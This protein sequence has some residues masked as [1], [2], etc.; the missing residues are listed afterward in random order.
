MS[1]RWVPPVHSPVFPGALPAAIA[2]AW[3]WRVPDRDGIVEALKARYDASDALLTDSGTSALILALQTIGRGATVAYPAY[4]CFDLTTAALGA[5][6]CVRLYDLD[7]QSLSPDLDSVREVIR[8]GVD[9]IVVAHLYGYAADVVGVKKLAADH[10][11]PVIEDA[12]QGAGGSLNGRR[13]GSLADISI[14]SFG[15]GK[16]MTTGSGGAVLVRTQALAPSIA[17]MRATI[18]SPARGAREAVSLGAQWLFAHP[19]LYRIPASIP[20]LRLGEM[21]FHAPKVPR[22][23]SASA[24]SLLPTALNADEQ[25][26]RDRRARVEDLVERAMAARGLA[27]VRPIPQSEP[28]YLRLPLLD[29]VGN[30]NPQPTI[31]AVRGYPLTLEQHTQLQALLA[32]KEHAGTGAIYLRD[33]LFTLATHAGIDTMD[34]SRL[35]SWLVSSRPISVPAL[36]PVTAS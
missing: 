3:G 14:L 27:A 24:A 26:I 9:A 32:P 21:V 11:I 33:R 17:R 23:M 30:A 31:G 28:G 4:G 19:S 10:G 6:M 36:S 8:R 35:T 1:W 12:A 15:R 5:G 16:G 13:L 25:Q 22:A 7:P 2:A 29:L 18:A 34:V 20:A